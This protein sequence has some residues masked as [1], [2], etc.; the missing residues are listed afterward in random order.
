MRICFIAPEFIPN[1]GGTG[2]YAINLMRRLPRDVE[3]HV[4]TPRRKIV[5]DDQADW[6]SNEKIQDFL[7]RPIMIH[8]LSVAQDTF[9]YNAQ[10]QFECARQLPRLA[11][12]YDFDIVHSNHCHM[13]DLYYQL[14]RRKRIRTVTTVHDFLSVKRAS[15]RRS[16]MEFGSL[17]Q[18]EKGIVTLYPFLRLCEV[19]YIKSI[20]V[21]IAPSQCIAG[22]LESFGVENEQIHVIRNGVD[23]SVF[24][25]RNQNVTQER[26]GLELGPTVLF[27][28]RLVSHKGIDTILRAIPTILRDV[29]D[30]QFVF[31]GAG[32]PTPY[33]SALN[34]PMI[35]R[36]VRFLGYLGNY[37]DMSQVYS[38]ATVFVLPSLFENCPMSVLEA[39]SCGIPVIATRVGG[40]PEI[41]SSGENGILIPPQD[42]VALADKVVALLQDKRYASQLAQR[43]RRTIVE[44]FSASRMA[45]ETVRLYEAML[46]SHAS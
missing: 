36:S 8:Y 38:R 22:I 1:W 25:P 3:I 44:K 21:F 29:P 23:V 46:D 9:F 34:D 28:G 27:T 15:I 2:A 26:S 31:T 37:F 18:S 16:G 14:A 35:K 10:F 19:L 6:R 30:A 39:M 12:Q 41:I 13:P 24:A 7:G 5:G 17:D 11:S 33:L 40:V 42:A 4:V 43:G 20:P 45:A 32:I